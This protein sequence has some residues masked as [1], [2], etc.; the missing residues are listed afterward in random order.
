MKNILLILLLS[1]CAYCVVSSPGSSFAV[2]SGGCLTCHRY[3]G[4]VKFEKPDKIKV[5]HIDEEK[6]LRSSHGKTDCRQCH[7]KTVQIPHTN[8]TEV[9]CNKNCHL[10]DKEKIDKIDRSYLTNFHKEERFAISRLDSGTSCRVCHPLY[11]HS[12]HNKVRAYIN[13]HLGY[14]LCE[15]CHL[16]K[17]GMQ[18]ITYDWKDPEEFE[19]LGQSSGTQNKV[20]TK[21]GS[22]AESIISKMLRIYSEERKGPDGSPE[23]VYYISRIAVYKT[24]NGEDKL[25]INSEDNDRARAFLEKEKKLSTEKRKKELDFFHRNIAKKEISVACNECHSSKGIMDFRQLGFHEKRAYDLEYMNIKG[26]VTKYDTFVIPNLFGPK[27]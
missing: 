8:V 22:S 7:P 12:E 24:E 13:M 10:D 16:K 14:T 4:L 19:Y 11:P 1:L 27:K 3:P 6:H 5:L 20:K 9:S 18:N 26:L 25:F 21:K 17:E 15:V 23:T 2:D